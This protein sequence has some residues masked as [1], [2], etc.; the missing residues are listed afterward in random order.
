M[1]GEDYI[2]D[3]LSNV[4]TLEDIIN[5]LAVLY[6]NME[7]IS[8][9]YYDIFLNSQAMEV[10]VTLYDENG[11]L[12]LRKIPNVASYKSSVKQGTVDPEGV[13]MGGIGAFYINTVSQT[14]FYKATDESNNGTSVD[15]WIKVCSPYE[16]FLQVDGEGTLLKNLNADSI[17]GGILSASH[18]GTGNNG[19][20][21][22]IL[23]AAGSEPYTVAKAGEDYIA[24][25]NMVGVVSYYAGN[26][27]YKGLNIDF[28]SSDPIKIND[29]WLVCNGAL[30]SKNEYPR[31]FG[32]IGTTY[33][34][35]E[36]NFNLPDLRDM[37]LKG[38]TTLSGTTVVESSVGP[39]THEVI[40]STG[41][42][43]PHSH[44]P[45]SLDAVGSIRGGEGSYEGMC[46]GGKASG[47]FTVVKA[48]RKYT[49]NTS[50]SGTNTIG[51]DFKLEGNM[52]GLTSSESAHTHS[53]INAQAAE[54]SGTET[55]VR[56]KV[57][58][59]IIKY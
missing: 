39:H 26:K 20:L 45:G 14:L 10:P 11:S 40:G 44:G 3:K 46:D 23:K 12:V 7:A 55:E 21:N 52:T 35:D 25:A 8:R 19:S 16:N 41:E 54:N 13:E 24:P 42:G 43:T 28:T 57:M 37:Y 53:L 22:G 48:K 56:H 29:G 59:P 2:K 38:G 58:I 18:G 34:G 47:V 30:V 49:S 1:A 4:R 15:G 17:T 6:N 36:D 33:G 27:D 5:V 51:F 31:L 9:N 50:N 32:V